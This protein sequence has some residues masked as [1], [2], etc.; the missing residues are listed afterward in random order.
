MER[1][2]LQNT[3]SLE[4]M[5][6]DN[7]N[8]IDDHTSSHTTKIA[9]DMANQLKRVSIPVFSGN[10]VKY[11]GEGLP[12]ITVLIELQ[13]TSQYK[14]LQLK[15]CLVGEPLKLVQRYG[16]SSA[17]Y[18]TAK[19]KLEKKYGWKRRQMAIFYLDRFKPFQNNNPKEV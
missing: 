16:H 14:L 12:L 7:K 5:Q 11:L 6:P 19:D 9:N 8:I 3:S 10:K 15:Q 4:K 2:L 1:S 18:T 17:A 13:Q